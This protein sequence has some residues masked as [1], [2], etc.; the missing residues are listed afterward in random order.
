VSSR[1]RAATSPATTLRTEAATAGSTHGLL[2]CVALPRTG[3]TSGSDGAVADSPSLEVTISESVTEWF[4]SPLDGFFASGTGP[5]LWDRLWMHGLRDFIADACVLVTGGFRLRYL[6]YAALVGRQGCETRRGDGPIGRSAM[7]RFLGSFYVPE[8][9]GEV[10]DR[11]PAL[12]RA[13]SPRRR[14]LD[15]SRLVA[16]I[17][18]LE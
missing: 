4:P 13:Y 3:V 6:G 10:Q 12:L 15:H 5:V 7:M 14:R 1:T 18:S 8:R 16:A 2:D 9:I 11:R 17:A